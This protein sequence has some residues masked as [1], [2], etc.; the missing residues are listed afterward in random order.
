MIA[1]IKFAA[2]AALFSCWV[3]VRAES[4]DAGATLPQVVRRAEINPE[5]PVFIPVNPRIATTITFPKPIG[6]PVGTGFIDAEAMQKAAA[7]GKSVGGRGEYVIAYVQ[8]ESSFTIQP[9]PKSDLLNLNV[10]Y[11][12]ITL[13]LYFYIVDKPLAAI[14]SLTFFEPGATAQGRGQT[15]AGRSNNPEKANITAAEI[16]RT[17]KVD[18]LPPS[19]FKSASPARL[20]GFLRKLKLVHAA[21]VGTELDDLAAAMKV[22]VAVSAAEDPSAKSIL[23]PVND[24]GLYQ[25]ILLRAVRDASLDA[26]GFIVLFRNASDRELVFDPRTL[27]ARCGA[28]LYTA[29]ICD[30]PA[31]L[32]PGELRPGYFAIVGSADGRPGYLLPGNDWRISVSLISPQVPLGQNVGAV[33]KGK[34]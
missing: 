1:W 16:P 7:E 21:H 25:L 26:V 13:V 29:Q 27:S 9:L 5:V 34:P 31:S 4:P 3:G 22:S 10:P 19:P 11:D 28:A 23:Q 17:K 14:A 15:V 6:E 24:S 20:E 32:K 18:S 33:E 30:A 2:V 8:G 12:G